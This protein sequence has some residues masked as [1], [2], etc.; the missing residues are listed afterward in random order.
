MPNT[1]SECLCP[2]GCA[3]CSPKPLP[4][5]PLHCFKV[6]D[7]G[8][9]VAPV[10]ACILLCYSPPMVK[11]FTFPD[12][13]GLHAEAAKKN[14]LVADMLSKWGYFETL[15]SI[16]VPLSLIRVCNLLWR[17]RSCVPCPPNLFVLTYTLRSPKR[18]LGDEIQ[19]ISFVRAFSCSTGSITDIPTTPRIWATLFRN[20]G[21]KGYYVH[22]TVT[23]MVVIEGP[24][25]L[26]NFPVLILDESLRIHI[27]TRVVPS[28]CQSALPQRP[29]RVLATRKWA[30]INFLTW[31]KPVE[32]IFKS[33]RP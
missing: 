29:L 10:M 14:H 32:E 26:E 12:V 2:V 27:S 1:S 3:D 33:I 7:V 18:F 8:G 5:F 31:E 22:L 28:G 16:V 25:G 13:S 15:L 21:N 30:I 23:G 4:S 20:Q 24:L 9:T 11:E 17:Y 6:G 19:L